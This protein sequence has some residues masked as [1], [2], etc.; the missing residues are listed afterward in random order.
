MKLSESEKNHRKCVFFLA[1]IGPIGSLESSKESGV[2]VSLFA[3]RF[4][5]RLGR[6]AFGEATIGDLGFWEWQGNQIHLI[7]SLGR[8]YIIVYSFRVGTVA[9]PMLKMLRDGA[10]IPRFHALYLSKSNKLGIV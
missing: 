7:I 2:C 6:G 8:R 9:D 5:A 1:A 4:L 3:L 10:S